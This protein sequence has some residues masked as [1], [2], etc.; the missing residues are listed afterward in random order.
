MIEITQRESKLTHLDEKARRACVFYNKLVSKY[1]DSASKVPTIRE[2]INEYPEYN[3]VFE[4]A[5]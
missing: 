4:I 2:V 1:F 5:K 3:I